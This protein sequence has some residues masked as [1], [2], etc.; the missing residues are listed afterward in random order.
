MDK[1][2]ERLMESEEQKMMEE[3]AAVTGT[4]VEGIAEAIRRLAGWQKPPTTQF[5]EVMGATELEVAK[6]HMAPDYPL[7]TKEDM[8]RRL[9]L[10]YGYRNAVYAGQFK[11]RATEQEVVESHYGLPDS[12][13]TISPDQGPADSPGGP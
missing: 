12:R 10:Q 9:R 5:E 1:T 11:A 7:R 4:T 8:L 2:L 6:A 3:A 13:T